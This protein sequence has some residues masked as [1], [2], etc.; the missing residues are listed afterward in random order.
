MKPLK[1]GER[2][3][4]S[5]FHSIN[6]V[7]MDVDPKASFT[8]ELLINGARQAT[9]HLVIKR[10]RKMERVKIQGKL[11]RELT[12]N[13]ESAGESIDVFITGNEDGTINYEF[14]Y[15]NRNHHI[16]RQPTPKHTFAP[17]PTST[18]SPPDA[19]QAASAGD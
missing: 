3:V 1:P 4:Q 6:W 16:L 11:S 7:D 8:L 15:G 18:D 5:S 10:K 17:P 19:A 14:R 9:M 12:Q 2:R 13:P